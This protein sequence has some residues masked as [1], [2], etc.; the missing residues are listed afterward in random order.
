VV[1]SCLRWR[2][3][4]S[5]G[6]PSGQIHWKKNIVSAMPFSVA[7]ASG[8][9]TAGNLSLFLPPGEGIRF[10]DSN[11]LLPSYGWLRVFHHH[12]HHQ[13]Q[14]QQQQQN[15]N[16]ITTITITIIQ[17]HSQNHHQ[18]PPPCLMLISGSFSFSIA[19]TC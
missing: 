14:K 16:Q 11:L 18:H 2:K 9:F 1:L 6:S 15:Q 7:A 17:N 3:P 8:I 5:A 19:E 4:A 12:H 10:H 13:Q